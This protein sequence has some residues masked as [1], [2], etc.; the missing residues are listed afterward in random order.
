MKPRM[1]IGASGA[2]PHQPVRTCVGCRERDSRSVLVRLALTGDHV[3]IDE[4][5]SRPGRGA[6][7]H[8]DPN[9]FALAHR[10]GA[11]GRALR[12]PKANVSAVVLAGN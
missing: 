10:R 6:W 5:G 12:A 7:L 4:N 11:I 3:V 8:S 1:P 2:L 9:C